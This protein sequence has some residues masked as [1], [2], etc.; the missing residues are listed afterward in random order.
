MD[1]LTKKL[2]DKIEP[3]YTGR[4][5]NVS[6]YFSELFPWDESDLKNPKLLDHI[7]R[8]KDFMDRLLM[9]G[10]IELD[11][12]YKELGTLQSNGEY[13]WLNTRPINGAIS[14]KG[15]DLLKEERERKRDDKQFI[16]TRNLTIATILISLVA[17]VPPILDYLKDDEKLQPSLQQIDTTLKHISS[18]IQSLRQTQTISN[19]NVN[20]EINDANDTNKKQ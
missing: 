17:I 8:L 16:I 14:K 10:L 1:D 18:D 9:Q 7:S 11:D 5:A 20:N 15:Y 2:L 12:V 19:S 3:T 6:H 13:R 4:Q